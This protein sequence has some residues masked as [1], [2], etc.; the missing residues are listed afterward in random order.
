MNECMTS[1]EF[2]G[3]AVFAGTAFF[4]WQNASWSLWDTHV[5]ARQL[6]SSRQAIAQS[7]L[8]VAATVE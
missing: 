1:E 3:T 4:S 2:G 7:I 8:S 5:A 6:S